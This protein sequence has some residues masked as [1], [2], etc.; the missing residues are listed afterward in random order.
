MEY[1]DYY[2]IMGLEKTATQDEIKK[3]YRKL[4]KKYHPDLN[5]NDEK[6]QE[7]FKSV[8]EAY[9]VLSD[10]K[11][12]KQYDQMGQYG[13]SNGQQF[14]PS[15]YGYGGQPGGSYTYSSAEGADFSDFFNTIF[16]GA[17]GQRSSSSNM[18]FDIGDLFGSSSGTRRSTGRTRATQ[19]QSYE[20]ELEISIEDG[21]SGTSREVS[22]N[23]G[24]ETK[25]IIVKIPKGITPGKKVKVKGDK[26][27][28]DADILFKINFRE[29]KDLHL[30]GLNLTRKIDLL[31]WEAYFG[32][33]VVVQTLSGKIKIDIPPKS[34]S[35]KKMRLSK[36]GYVDLKGNT[37]DLYVEISI[38]NPPDL[39]KEELELY[40]KLKEKSTYNP[41]NN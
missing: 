41:R 35:G 13:F 1:K 25:N 5:P 34:E 9:E 12:R 7:K 17:G 33:K 6:A 4:A 32:E 18:G 27:G 26:W 30:D 28:I 20:S 8:S 22:L 10:E 19:R 11:K 37:G 31:P 29:S 16:G 36:K 39:S 3:T 2:K 38:V 24:G 21:Y 14:D 23:I 40:K 15:A